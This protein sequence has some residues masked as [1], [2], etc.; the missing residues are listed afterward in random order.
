MI[1]LTDYRTA[2]T[3]DVHLLDDIVYPQKVHWFPDTYKNAKM[4]LV[5]PP[6]KMAD[7]V[8]DPQ[9]ME[10]IKSTPCKTAF[11]LA[12]GN[13]HFAGLNQKTMKPTQLTY[14][15]KITPLLS[16]Q[17]YAGRVAQM[18]GV[19]DLVMTDASACV[20]SLKV[21]QDVE[22]LI[23]HRGFD[24]VIVLSIEDPISN[25]VLEMFGETKATL[26]EADELTG[27]VPSAFDSTNYGFHL[28]QGAVLAVFESGKYTKDPKAMLHGT[29]VA[30]ELSTN[31]LGQREDGQG[32]VKAM[33]EAF[34]SSRSKH[35]HI[36]VIKTHGTG[37]KSNNLAERAAIESV[38]G[39]AGYIATSF[40]QRIGHTMG[41][42]GLL[43]SC[44]LIDSIKK[45]AIPEIPNRTE[46][47]RVFISSAW[48]TDKNVTFMSLAAGMGNIYAASIFSTGI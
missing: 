34:E 2:C 43:E 5:Y 7:K 20:S 48:L 40:K 10:K 32:Y 30:S 44:L 45:G 12:S 33:I 24:R 36:D 16:T 11:I 13:S 15:Y 19:E 42:S 17:I 35:Y 25:S 29:G 38:F 23:K 9:L 39:K 4:G 26:T 21:L 27:V 46:L 37:T 18:F 28:G 3:E 1:Y 14:E 6:H 41:A 31:P 8:L 22:M 47:D